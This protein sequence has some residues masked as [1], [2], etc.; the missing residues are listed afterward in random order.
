M[1]IYYNSSDIAALINK[2]PYKTQDET[3]HNILCKINKI[4]NTTDIDKFNNLNKNDSI[5]LLDDFYN[6]KKI[7]DTDFQL[8]K[9]KIDNLSNQHDLNKFNK[10]I[11]EHISK[12][13]INISHTNDC[14]KQQNELNDNLDK[15]I[16]KDNSLIKEYMNSYINKNRGIK[17]E[18]KIIKEYSKKYNTNITHNNSKLYKHKLFS[19][20]DY[21]FFLCGKIDGIENDELIE[22]KNRKNR[23]FHKIPEYEQI[24]IQCYFILTKLEKGK[25][26]ENFNDTQNIIITQNNIELSNYIIEQLRNVSNIIIS[27]LN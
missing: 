10:S 9:N 7:S 24:Q 14:L 2:N 1:N 25:L 17:N 22:I 19:I 23:L 3:I 18:N 26:I 4:E 16:T 13:C 12:Q 11:I 27:K 15:I 6:T 8:Y 5:K 21:N 20:D